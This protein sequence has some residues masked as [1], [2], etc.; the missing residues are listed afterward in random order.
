MG[1]PLA[2][3]IYDLLKSQPGFR[4]SAHLADNLDYGDW[5]NWQKYLPRMVTKTD[6]KDR[7]GISTIRKQPWITIAPTGSYRDW[8]RKRFLTREE[9]FSFVY[10]Y[11]KTHSVYATGSLS[12]YEFYGLPNIENV[13]WM[14]SD[15]LTDGN[16]YHEKIDLI[17][18]IR[19]ING[20]ES[21]FSTD[22]YL[23][24]YSCLTELPTFVFKTK[25]GQKKYKEYGTDATDFI[26]L[27]KEIWKT[28]N[29]I[30]IEDF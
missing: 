12:D 30:Q 20:S 10:K 19:I 26:F 5:K 11:S 7:F 16:Y 13:F 27:N 24:T 15:Y 3:A 23:K 22:T 18:M 25:F 6:W 8:N 17:E 4:Q 28:L 1:Q 29:F 9:F 2:N 14:T 21:V